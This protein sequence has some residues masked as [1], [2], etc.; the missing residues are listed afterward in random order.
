MNRVSTYDKGRWKTLFNLKQ[1]IKRIED[2]STS[3]SGNVTEG[4]LS[5]LFNMLYEAVNSGG[6]IL[7][8]KYGHW[9]IETIDL[10]YYSLDDALM[11]LLY[12]SLDDTSKRFIK[13]DSLSDFR[14]QSYESLIR[15]FDN[16]PKEGI[17]FI[18]WLPV[19][20]N[21]FC[22]NRLIIDLVK[23]V[24]DSS[25]TKIAGLEA[26]GFLLAQPIANVL[27]VPF[28][29]IRKKGKL[30]GKCYSISYSLEYGEA[31]IEIQDGT[32]S[33]TDNVLVVDDLLATGGT[34]SAANELI[35]MHT[36]AIQNLFLIELDSLEGWKKLKF[37]HKSLLH[38]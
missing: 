32:I 7:R 33:A 2:F 22:F 24:K 12:N 18:D 20:S 21:P 17:K 8:D 28:V 16:F 27:G 36:R 11:Q 31:S 6:V 34:V 26:R 1:Q 14:F 3:L 5:N 23:L 4:D 15:T 38:R 29:P 30:P 19:L 37:G 25:F 9:V 35:S 13:V 10:E